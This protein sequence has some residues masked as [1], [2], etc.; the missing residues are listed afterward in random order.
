VAL[1]ERGRLDEAAARFDA[2]LRADP[3]QAEA[4]VNLGKT[5]RDR[6]N[7]E[8]A[9][10]CFTRALAFFPDSRPGDSADPPPDHLEL[11]QAWASVARHARVEEESPEFAALLERCFASPRFDPEPLAGV[12]ARL[13][14]RRHGFSDGA[15]ERT[16]ATVALDTLA[17]DSLLLAW[18][19][20]V[21]NVDGRLE[22]FLIVLRR[23]L[24]FALTTDEE[25]PPSGLRLAAALARQGLHNEHVF[26]KDEEEG[27]R[28]NDLERRLETALESG[29]KAAGFDP[30][31]MER[32]LTLYAMYRP[33]RRLREVRR[34]LKAR[35]MRR[36]PALRALLREAVLEPFEE[37][38][39]ATTLRRI[40]AIDDATSLAVA[41][42]Y[43]ENPVPRWRSAG[44]A[45]PMNFARAFRR[46]FPHFTPPRFPPAPFLSGPI[47]IL[48][49]GGGTGRHPIAVA[50]AFTNASVLAVD[51][52]AASLAYA[53]RKAAE[54]GLRNLEFAQADILTLGQR[55]ETFDVIE[56][57]GVLHH[58]QDPEQGLD[59]LLGR[60]RDGGLMRIGLYSERARASIAAARERLCEAGAAVTPRR[61]RAVRRR[62][63]AENQEDEFAALLK[64]NDFFTMSGCRDLLFH[65]CE[66]AFTL[67]R[68]EAMLS[69]R[70]L[71]L[72]G[73][74]LDDPM[75]A[76]AYRRE[77]PDDPAMT[78]LEQWGAFEE[79]HPHTFLGMYD[80]WCRKALG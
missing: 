5:E 52:S 65:V 58:M 42:Q 57:V 12:A 37:A 73:F 66:H 40:G 63:L 31:G 22:R 15:P 36:S 34:L 67:P 70:E 51:L 30:E 54:L 11:L 61:I 28:L 74:E 18:L 47:R 53:A 4:L 64:T 50:R 68:I 41:A 27:R 44:F 29:L 20:Q 6:G 17:A 8:A 2:A 45:H 75:I 24:L 56:C 55:D 38:E 3:G 78:D 10:A 26:Y 19:E 14:A 35:A 23:R 71:S 60:L 33:L 46:T 62:A 77:F 69:N 16:A 43:E 48:I 79:R 25:A 72:I 80:F 59:M 1:R 49:A 32:D 21:I 9:A 7:L 76:A 13:L 39:I